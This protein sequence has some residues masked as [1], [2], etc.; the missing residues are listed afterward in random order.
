MSFNPGKRQQVKTIWTEFWD[1]GL[2]KAWDMDMKV[3]QKKQFD[4]Q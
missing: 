2:K 3:L 1:W 4:M